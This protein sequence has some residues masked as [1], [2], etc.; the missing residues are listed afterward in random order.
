MAQE[1]KAGLPFNASGPLT[2][3]RAGVERQFIVDNVPS[4]DGPE[5]QFEIANTP[6]A[7]DFRR[8]YVSFSGYF[9]SYGPQV[10]AAAPQLVDALREA[11]EALY[12]Y[13]PTAIGIATIDAALAAAGAAK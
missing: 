11:R 3:R 4:E 9:G 12:A 2:V 7:V 1:T 8:T 10:F 13:S 5:R 6:S